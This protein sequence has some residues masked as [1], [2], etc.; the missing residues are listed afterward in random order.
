MSISDFIE[1]NR[2]RIDAVIKSRCPN[3]RIDS[4]KERRLWILNEQS[5]YSWARSEGVKI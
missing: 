5:L 1:N 2:K 4:D 3:C